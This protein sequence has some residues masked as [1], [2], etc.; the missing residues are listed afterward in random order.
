LFILIC[1]QAA[2]MHWLAASFVTKGV[3]RID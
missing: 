1:G 3:H 2:T